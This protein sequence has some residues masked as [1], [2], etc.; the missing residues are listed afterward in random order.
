MALRLT[1]ALGLLAAAAATFS[2]PPLADAA[3]SSRELAASAFADARATGSVHVTSTLWT[4]SGRAQF[5]ADV[6]DGE[7]RVTIKLTYAT[8][9]VV[10]IGDVAYARSS[11]AEGLVHFIRWPS[12]LAGAYSGRWVRYPKATSAFATLTADTSLGSTLDALTPTGSLGAARTTTVAGQSA[13]VIKG[14]LPPSA[15]FSDVTLYVTHAAKPLP[16]REVETGSGKL[17]ELT[18]LSGWGKHLALIAPAG[19]VAAPRF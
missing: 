10:Q 11:T 15:P 2:G 18:V 8:I 6:G 9:D 16:L 14:K 12:R 13:Q 3:Q 5:A 7:G 4:D 17:Y 19:S 1:K